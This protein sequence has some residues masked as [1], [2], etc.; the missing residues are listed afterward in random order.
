M[1]TLRYSDAVS[2]LK[3]KTNNVS[4]FYIIMPS[5]AFAALS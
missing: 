4:L 3:Y 1:L 2:N 5:A